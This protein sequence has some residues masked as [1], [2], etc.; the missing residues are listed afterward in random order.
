MRVDF[1]LRRLKWFYQRGKRGY[2]DCD[3]WAIDSY[4]SR[5][6]PPMLKQFKSV[7]NGYPGCEGAATP[8]EWDK[9]LD[10]MIEGWEAAQNV[11]AWTK[12]NETDQALFESRMQVFI[13]W[14][15]QLWD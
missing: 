14:F 9:R 15:F 13:K 5:I 1:C 7:T 2:A 10:E 4:L 6:I 12:S 11:T 8:E 3:V